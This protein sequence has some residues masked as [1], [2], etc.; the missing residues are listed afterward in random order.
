MISISKPLGPAT[1]RDYYRA[2]YSAAANS[3]YYSENQQLKGDWVG[4]IAAVFGL[5]GQQIRAEH[6]DRLA[7]GQHPLS[8]EQLIAHRKTVL[9]EAGKEVAHRAAFDLVFAPAKSV[10]VTA[11][12]GGDERILQAHRMAV[13]EALGEAETLIQARGGGNRAPINTGRMIAAVFDHD[14]A[15]PVE[16]YQACQLH[17]HCVVMNLTEDHNGQ[18]RSLQPSE[19]YVAQQ[20]LASVYQ[21]HLEIELRKLG[22]ELAR[23]KNNSV[24]IVGYT[25]EYL[26]SESLRSQQITEAVEAKGLTGAESREIAA[27]STREKK[28][29]LS[30]EEVRAAHKANA[31][32]YG[33]QPAIVVAAARERGQQRGIEAGTA[34]KAVRFARKKLAER[35]AVFDHHQVITEALRY[36]RGRATLGQIKTE[37]Q[38]EREQGRLIEVSHVRPS[39]PLYRYTTREGIADER[40]VIEAIRNAPERAAV[41]RFTDESLKARYPQ[42]NEWQIRVIRETLASERQ[43]TGIQGSAGTG[44]T[45]TLKA[46]RDLAA[47]AGYVAHGLAP[48]SGAARALREAGIE[49]S[50]T[51]QKH[52][53]RSAPATGARIFFL[54]E[55]SLTAARQMRQ[56]FSILGPKDRVVIVG[57]RRQHDSIE[58]GRIFEELQIAGMDTSRVNKLVRQ[59][60][61]GLR[62]VVAAMARGRT[63]EAVGMLQEQGRVH[64]IQH[65]EERFRAIAEAYAENPD[66]TLVISPDNASREEL[67]R[68]IRADLQGRGVVATH[69]QYRA[70]I[71]VNKQQITVED[72]K[73]AG[74]YEVGDVVRFERGATGLKVG[75]KEYGTVIASDRVSNQITVK[76]DTGRVVKYDPETVRAAVSVYEPHS[77]EFSAGDRLQFTAPVRKERIANRDSGRVLSVDKSGNARVALDSGRKVGINLARNRH[78]DWGYVTTSHASQ[79]S[80]V[81][82][83]LVHIDTGDTRIRNLVTRTLGYVA[84]SRP[85]YDAQVF[86]DDAGK[87]SASLMRMKENTT[88][89]SHDQMQA[90]RSPG[91]RA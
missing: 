27:H 25:P 8:G 63:D 66:S 50:E 75:K 82:R 43:T 45:T 80:T 59:K 22:Y 70:T 52:L 57:D 88:A 91:R 9:T 87:L 61:E 30:Q 78:I 5:E 44:K 7:E 65:R 86:T 76:L 24:D 55:S 28:Q 39:A 33:N 36:A 90:Y 34:E 83:V 47:A 69:G 14:S 31:E 26:A 19:L 18:A 56:F 58:A 73:L 23:G 35:E 4:K 32:K 29:H 42:M 79:G 40:D 74:S 3:A 2:D 60:D 89:L 10:S 49:N 12:V 46:I 51:L 53:R 71:L 11:L 16:N 64:S 68:V 81:D 15:R 21:N 85:R 1:V 20:M 17:S 72:T 38:R 37:V 84:L 54:D 77:R 48:T 62:Q 6:F 67:N 41:A 13:R